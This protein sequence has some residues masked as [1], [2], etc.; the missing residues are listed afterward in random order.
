MKELMSNL[1]ITIPMGQIILLILLSFA[2][3]LFGKIKSALITNFIFLF[4]WIST[5]YQMVAKKFSFPLILSLSGNYIM[6]VSL[7]LFGIALIFFY[8]I[9]N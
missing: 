1:E 5:N 4:Y 6:I 7:I 9:F 2:F 8:E 3:V